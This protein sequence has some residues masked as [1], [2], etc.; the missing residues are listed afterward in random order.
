[1][2]VTKQ[3]FTSYHLS[4][5]DSLSSQQF[6]QWMVNSGPYDIS[7]INTTISHFPPINHFRY[8]VSYDLLS[9][10]LSLYLFDP[11]RIYSINDLQQVDF[12]MY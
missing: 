6:T 4:L 10:S 7:R 1:M 11:K 8:E 9:T 2:N 12:Q 3:C 5:T